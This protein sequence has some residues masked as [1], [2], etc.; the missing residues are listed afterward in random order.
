[1]KRLFAAFCLAVTTS[2]VADDI[3]Y[4]GAV[5]G[6]YQT[7]SADYIKDG[8]STEVDDEFTGVLDLDVDIKAGP[9]FW[10]I[11][12]EGTTTVQDGGV[13]SVFGDALADA[14]AAVGTDGKGR[15]QI[16]SL[17]YIYSLGEGSVIAGLVYPSGFAESGDWTNDEI[18]QFV[19]SP[20]VNMGSIAVPDYAIGVGYKREATE[21]SLGWSVLLSQAEGLA[22][23]DGSYDDLLSNI[24]E[25]FFF[26]VEV[27][28]LV[29][30]LTAKLGIW[31]NDAE[32]DKLDGSGTDAI[33]GGN[34]SLVKDIDA[35]RIVLRYGVADEDVSE[36]SSFASL[37]YQYRGGSLS[38]GLGY[39]INYASDE[40]DSAYEDTHYVEA[41]V[42][43]ELMPQIF[44]TGS[45]QQVEDDGLG[46]SDVEDDSST[47]FTLRLSWQF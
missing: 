21:H 20:F 31:Q 17:E 18:T 12:V 26:N 45:V 6:F 13:T 15:I 37:F 29:M 40:L 42:N 34:I 7:T 16:S 46:M 2:A 19:S 30:G 25:D 5:T 36:V 8:V 22:D 4:V 28:A 44:V 38:G 10:H 43:Y 11:Y 9:G 14:G 47:I 24:D 3:S 41:Y 27:T 33:L 39:A 32:F 1:M 23:R 35:H